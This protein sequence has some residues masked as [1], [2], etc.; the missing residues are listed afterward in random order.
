MRADRRICVYIY[1]NGQR[2]SLIIIKQSS[3]YILFTNLVPPVI[4]YRGYLEPEH[5][6]V[7]VPSIESPHDELLFL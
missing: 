4:T 3:S 5:S 1:D 2:P 7:T 6:C